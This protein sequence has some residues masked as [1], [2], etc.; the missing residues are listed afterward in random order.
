MGASEE[1]EKAM[2]IASIVFVILYVL[3]TIIN[4]TAM[5]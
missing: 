4:V 3:E 2:D 5:R 1:E